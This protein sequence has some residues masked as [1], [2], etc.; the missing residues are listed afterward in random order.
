MH[1]QAITFKIVCSQ[2]PGRQIPALAY[3]AGLTRTEISIP[4]KSSGTP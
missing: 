1:M 3:G 4:R 2:S